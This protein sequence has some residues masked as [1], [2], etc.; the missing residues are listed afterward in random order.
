MK[1]TKGEGETVSNQEDAL[2]DTIDA[3]EEEEAEIGLKKAGILSQTETQ[4]SGKHHGK[5]EPNGQTMNGMD[6]LESMILKED[7]LKATGHQTES[8]FVDLDQ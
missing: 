1:N 3:I 2:I 8:Q 5:G 6:G 4:Q 7:A